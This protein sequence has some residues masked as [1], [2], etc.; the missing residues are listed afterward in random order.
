MNMLGVPP[1]YL[2]TRTHSWG[3]SPAEVPSVIHCARAG[4]ER[5]VQVTGPAG[6]CE[7]L[8]VSKGEGDTGSSRHPEQR[9][10]FMD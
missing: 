6:E 10:G 4:T 2:A 9:V 5:C 7:P 8:T 1:V 3:L